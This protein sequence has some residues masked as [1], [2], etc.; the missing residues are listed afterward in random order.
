[1]RPSE[2]FEKSNDE[3]V[4]K[5]EKSPNNVIPTGQG[6]SRTPAMDKVKSDSK[7]I[8]STKESK[9]TESI[10]PKNFIPSGS[11]LPRTPFIKDQSVPK[12]DKKVKNHPKSPEGTKDSKLI[13]STIDSKSIESTKPKN[14]IP[15]GSDLPRTPFIKGQSK[16]SEFDIPTPDKEASENVI[17]NGKN[18]PRTPYHGSAPDQDLTND[19]SKDTL[20]AEDV[21]DVEKAVKNVIPG[22]QEIPRTPYVFIFIYLVYIST[23][24]LYTCW[25]VTCIFQRKLKNPMQC[26]K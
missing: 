6:L 25:L 4:E 8:E 9:S 15:S 26:T 14:L 3:K 2:L 7:S 22:G 21:N 20:E 19:T 10:K 23:S 1:M 17:P 16:G 5:T 18:L 24:R 13:E 12:Q 11:D